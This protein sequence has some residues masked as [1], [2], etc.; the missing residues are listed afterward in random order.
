MTRLTIFIAFCFA[1]A[2]SAQDVDLGAP[3]GTVRLVDE[4]DCADAS[5]P[6]VFREAPAGASGI[7]AVLG[8]PARTMASE[9][10]ARYFAYRIGAG[11]TPGRQYVLEVEYPEDTP[12]SMFIANRG[13]ETVRGISTGVAFGDSVGGYTNN[14]LE[15]FDYPLSGAYER[16]R[17]LFTLSDHFA[18]IQ[19]ARGEDPRPGTPAEGFWVIVAQLAAS[20]DPLSN[21]AAVSR[22]RLYEVPDFA[23]LIAPIVYPPD[24]L[25]RRFVFWR[26]EMTNTFGGRGGQPGFDD[27]RDFWRAQIRTMQ[28]LAINAYGKDLLEFGAN[29]GWDSTQYGGNRWV[30]QSD[31]PS[32]W[33]TIL[34]LLAEHDLYAMPY[35]EFTG[36]KGDEG[37]G[38]E[39]RAEPLAR[40]TYDP[41]RPNPQCGGYTHI[42]W[43]EQANVDVS[44]PATF[45]DFRRMLEITIVSQ[46]DRAQFAGAWIRNRVSDMPIGFGD[47]TRARFSEQANGGVAIT[48][49]DLMNDT[50]LY[51]RYRAWWIGQRRAFFEQV[52]DYL[53]R[54]VGED[55]AVL[56][57]P[58]SGESGPNF[59]APVADDA[60]RFDGTAVAGVRDWT[61]F[62]AEGGYGAALAASHVNWTDGACDTPYEWHHAN[63][64]PDDW[65]DAEGLLFTYPFNRM[66]SVARADELDRFRGPAGLAAVRH[67]T[68]NEDRMEGLL[69]YFVSDVDRPGA[70][71]MLA[72]ARAFANGDPRYLGYLSS[73]VFNRASPEHTRAFNQ[74][75][76]ALPALPSRIDEGAASSAEVIVRVIATASHGTYLGV[77]HTGLAPLDDV[78]ITL[79][80]SGAVRDVVR[81]ETLEVEGGAVTLDLYPGQLY[82]LHLDA[83]VEPPPGVDAGTGGDAGMDG[84]GPPSGG[85]GCR[86][87]GA[88][89]DLALLPFVLIL[90]FVRRR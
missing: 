6:H 70:Y 60:T 31:D 58:Y 80:E 69:G 56:Y 76:L 4:V 82:A 21:G 48:R 78:R 32:R 59:G 8:A 47:A 42:G 72:E 81:D 88:R 75:F 63:P 62:V 37:L 46:R 45:E 15:S 28:F 13:G 67:Y 38:F 66:F 41:D 12:R 36:S 27:E 73:H 43:S 30:Y 51:D 44:D 52:R 20:D 2:A 83:T 50:A 68:L 11:L 77:V 84:D 7:G 54:E 29:Q 86:A 35:Y 71:S 33:Q 26:E 16:W 18:D 55:L 89:T 39:R 34:D 1:A 10:G 53:H 65:R 85:C 3:Y 5:D 61:T 17:M 40:P 25:P 64:P 14:V 57:T 90:F 9:G 23:P 19:L 24:D 74:A 22:I 79:P 49:A 87:V